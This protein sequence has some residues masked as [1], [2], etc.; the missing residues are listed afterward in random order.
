M[1]FGKLSRVDGVNFTL[2]K[3]AETRGPLSRT[4]LKLHFGL[5]L[6]LENKWKG[7]LYSFESTSLLAQYS[8]KIKS[9]ELNSTHYALPAP[10]TLG[11]WLQD[12][13]ED[14]SFCPKILKQISHAANPGEA[15]GLFKKCVQ[16][17]A[18]FGNKL[19][20]AFMQFP[21]TFSREKFADLRMLLKAKPAAMKL[22]IEFRHSSWFQEGSLDQSV[23]QLLQETGTSSVLLDVAGR[24]DLLHRDAFHKYLM[25]RFIG[26]DHPSDFE[27][28]QEWKKQLCAYQ[29]RGLEECYFFM[30]TPD[31]LQ[32]PQLLEWFQQELAGTPL[33]KMDSHPLIEN[34]E[35]PE[36]QLTLF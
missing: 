28:L 20:P 26:N 2:P 11:Q 18:D 23:A 15:V 17:L 31:N 6:W 30:H 3:L 33:L 34:F 24:R 9:I 13:P 4:P 8:K 5:P 16:V 36:A 19:G 12:T 29:E 10:K 27:R 7:S 21:P 35:P 14:F 1:E 22:C 25:I 32:A